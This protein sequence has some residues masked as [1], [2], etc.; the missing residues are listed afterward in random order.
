L[1]SLEAGKL[2][3]FALLDAEIPVCAPVFASL[4]I[5]M[6][7][8]LVVAAILAA[9]PA[10]VG[11]IR[12]GDARNG[13]PDES[14]CQQGDVDSGSVVALRHWDSP[15]TLSGGFDGPLVQIFIDRG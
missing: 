9:V 2:A 6:T 7:T 15:L 13:H 8:G 1:G 5:V 11:V 10:T 4:V 12:R 3:D 14:R